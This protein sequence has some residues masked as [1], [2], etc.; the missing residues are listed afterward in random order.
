MTWMSMEFGHAGN[1]AGGDKCALLAK[2][3]NKK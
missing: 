2:D 3:F 1:S